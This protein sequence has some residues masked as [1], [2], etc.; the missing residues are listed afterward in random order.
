M[1][2][3]CVFDFQKFSSSFPITSKR[4]GTVNTATFFHWL[5]S[6][7]VSQTSNEVFFGSINKP[8]LHPKLRIKFIL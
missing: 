2:N 4:F 7:T 5:N 1:S 8:K 6:I 3:N